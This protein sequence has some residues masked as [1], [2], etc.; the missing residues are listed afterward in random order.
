[1]IRENIDK[2]TDSFPEFRFDMETTA[3]YWI[4][5]LWKGDTKF[6]FELPSNEDETN[7]KIKLYL[8]DEWDIFDGE[9]L[10]QL[11]KIT[12]NKLNGE[13]EQ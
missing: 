6:F 4:I 10:D 1:M 12:K 8:D 11:I 2:V 5:Y 13:K 9:D 3:G 7:I